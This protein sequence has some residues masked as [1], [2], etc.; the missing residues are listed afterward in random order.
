MS[1]PGAIMSARVASVIAVHEAHPD[2]DSVRVAKELGLTAEQVRHIAR[3]RDLPM[4]TA[5]HN[6]GGRPGIWTEEILEAA[7]T[8]WK[9]GS[10][11]ED[12]AQFISASINQPVSRDAV[13]GKMWR[14]GIKSPKANKPYSKQPR[15]KKVARPKNINPI[16]AARAKAVG[17]SKAQ[18]N[19]TRASSPLLFG[20]NP[21]TEVREPN[22]AIG[23]GK[24]FRPLP[25]THPVD[26]NHRKGCCWIVS[27]DERPVL[28]CDAP[29][30]T[31]K[32]HEYSWCERHTFLAHPNLRVKVEAA[33]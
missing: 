22:Y 25:G 13:L 15:V 23:R 3:R 9:G 8:L 4:P 28:Y 11:A 16:R 27:E 31:F 24:N 14:L 30:F 20:Q 21:A 6:G 7:K 26:L 5:E 2:W 19:A 33:A 10:S 12:I 32:D 29:K 1:T 17:A 18:L